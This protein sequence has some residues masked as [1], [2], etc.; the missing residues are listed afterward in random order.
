M[1]CKTTPILSCLL[2]GASCARKSKNTPKTTP[3]CSSRMPTGNNRTNSG[4]T[5]FLGN[6]PQPDLDGLEGQGRSMPFHTVDAVL[7]G[8]LMWGLFF[9][10][11]DRIMPP[12]DDMGIYGLFGTRPLRITH[13]QAVVSALLN[14]RSVEQRVC[15]T[16]VPYG[17][18]RYNPPVFI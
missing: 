10:A 11:T 14:A 17:S 2:Q 1:M 6:L 16:P 8:S 9:R 7:L 12:P 4:T 15:N 5:H 13:C 18:K 3:S